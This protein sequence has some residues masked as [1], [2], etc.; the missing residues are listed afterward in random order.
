M[1]IDANVQKI[2]MILLKKWKL[3]VCF[4]LI[5]ILLAYFYTANFT[6]LSYVSSVQF[7]AYAVDTNQE[8][9]DSSSAQT[10]QQISNTSKMNY[11]MKM[12]DT[13]VQVF[14][15]NKFNQTVADELNESLNT[16]YSASTI[17]G[18]TSIETFDNTA[19]FKI[20]VTTT[21][22]ELSYQ[23]AHQLEKTIPEVMKET[24][25]GLV[26]ASV[27]DPALKATTSE[28][29]GYTK[30]CLIG[31]IAGA[32]LAAAYIILRELLDVRVKTSDE[33]SEI[34]DIPVLGSIPEFE[35]QAPAKVRSRQSEKGGR[36]NA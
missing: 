3:I 2:I 33:L 28:S 23:I 9:T 6:K 31:M 32:V 16:N 25:S 15:T 5:G 36:K 10:Q 19:F 21:D 13:Y 35:F 14:M 1:N 17:K 27:Q 11:A 12:M 20:S 29:L 8:F 18:A 4:A 7:L 24:N 22:A 34:Y 30:K 26:N